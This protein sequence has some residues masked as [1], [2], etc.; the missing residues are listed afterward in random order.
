MSA[1]KHNKFNINLFVVRVVVA[2]SVVVVVVVLEFILKKARQ[3][4][5][6]R[7]CVRVFYL[8]RVCVRARACVRT[9]A[10]TTRNNV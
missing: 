2:A 6:S 8:A 10:R 4:S 9:S 7:F 5:A 3:I 1:G